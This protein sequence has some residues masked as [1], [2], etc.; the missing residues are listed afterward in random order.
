MLVCVTG[1]TGFVGV[2]SV[3]E[4]VRRGHRVRILARDPGTAERGLA[5]LAVDPSAVG[6]VAGDV[7]VERD[8][9]R[10]VAGADAVLHAASVYSFDSR[11]HAAMRATNA[12]GTE[13]VLGAARRAGAAR[14]VHVSSVVA[15]LPAGPG[16]LHA[17]T[18]VGRPREA[19]MASK[20]AAERIARRHQADGAPVLITYPPALLGPHDPGPGD[21]NTRLRN[22]LRGLMPLWPL[23][24]FPVGDVRDTARLH[25]DLLTTHPIAEAP[26]ANR[27]FAPGRHVP[28][29]TYLRTLREVTGRSLP[30]LHLPAAPMLPVGAL[31]TAAQRLWPWHIPAEYGAIYTC[32]HA[33]PVAASASTGG[34]TPRPTAETMT[35]TIR[36]L[37]DR[38]L[39]TA[40]QAGRAL[41]AH[42]AEPG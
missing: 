41:D 2:H 42:R 18:P 34:L 25:A 8:V 4:L 1:G 40:H 33:R 21:Q 20:A 23:G 19:Y 15:L 38:G 27:H 35:D 36:W 31:A 6:V 9:R 14:I 29:R 30:A 3:A 5:A 32:A 22:T 11:H 12:R 16:P 10:A 28:T 37:H 24:G 17:D 26:V 39:L 7:T 13:L